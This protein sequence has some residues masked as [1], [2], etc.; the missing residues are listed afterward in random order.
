MVK[1]MVKAMEVKMSLE[2][3][4]EKAS[5]DKV[6]VGMAIETTSQCGGG[7]CGKSRRW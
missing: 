6:P 1:A 4:A 7:E 3:I 5:M 2:N